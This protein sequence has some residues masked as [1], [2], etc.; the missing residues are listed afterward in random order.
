[1][2]VAPHLEKILFCGLSLKSMGKYTNSNLIGK[3]TLIIT[4]YQF[5]SALFKILYQNIGLLS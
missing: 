1:M 2:I 5:S 3:I 4:S